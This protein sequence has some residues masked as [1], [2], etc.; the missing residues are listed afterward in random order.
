[1]VNSPVFLSANSTG[2]LFVSSDPNGSVGTDPD[3]GKIVRLRDVDGDGRADEALDFVPALNAPRGL[4]ADGNTVYVLHPPHIS[5]FIDKDGDGRADE[6][7]VLVKNI[8]WSYADRRADHGSNGLELGIDGWLYAAIGDFGFLRAEGVDGRTLQMRGGGIVRVRPDGTGM[9]LFSAGTRNVLEAAI[10]PLLDGFARDNTNDGGGWNTRFHHFSGLEDHGYPRLYKNFAAEAVAPLADYGGGSGC[11]AAWLSEPGWP[12]DWNHRPIT[13]DWG[14]ETVMAHTVQAAGAGF[15]ESAPPRALVSLKTPPKQTN[16]FRPTDVDVD[17]RG[18]LYLASWR[19]GGFGAGPNVG[20]LFRVHPQGRP[21][22]PLLQYESA[23]PGDLA[24]LMASPSHRTRLDAQRTLIR[25]PASA[26]AITALEEIASGSSY[27]LES[28]VAALFTLT[29]WQ[30]EKSLEFRKKLAADPSVAAWAIRSL[31]DS[32]SPKH[33]LP[34]E[35]VLA[36]LQSTDARTRRES[37]FAIARSGSLQEARALI[38]LLEDADPLVAHMTWRALSNL[39]AVQPCL[40]VVGDASASETRREGALRALQTLYTP[41]VVEGLIAQLGKETDF[42]RKKG[43]LSALSRLFYREGEWKGESWGTRPDHRGPLYQP[44]PWDESEKIGVT[45][46]TVMREFNGQDAAW[47]GGELARHRVRLN[48]ATR[49][50]LTLAAQDPSVVTTLLRQLSEAED[51]PQNALPLLIQMATDRNQEKDTRNDAVIALAKTDSREAFAAI[52]KSFALPG[53][54]E[55]YWNARNAFLDA[56]HLE[57]H[58]EL[59]VEQAGSNEGASLFAEEALMR[60]LSRGFGAPEARARA[61]EAIDQGWDKDAKRRRQI[62]AAARNTHTTV[63]AK[64]IALLTK[65]PEGP[66]TEL[67]NQYFKTVKLNPANLL[68]EA[69][70]EKLVGAM[71]PAEALEKVLPLKGDKNR[72]QQLFTQQGCVACHTVKP[73]QALKGPYLGNIAAT[74][75]KRELA[76]SILEP[77]KSIAQ[78]FATH[79]FTLKNGK[80]HTGFVVREAAFSVTFRTA[81]AQELTIPSAEIARREVLESV[82]LMPPGLAGS[83]SPEEFASLL[84]YL[85]SLS[86]TP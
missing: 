3:K 5:A 45:L 52:L 35:P 7:R 65:E 61:M 79:I 82:S 4:V 15:V 46:A 62:I 59:F 13:I 55:R 64:K 68:K 26:D 24:R 32:A 22:A 37:V 70:A 85:E 86:P 53:G 58:C 18:Y 47:L 66:L 44:E 12:A 72:G 36:G 74:Y 17:A 39:Q 8:G 40:E 75:K 30:P 25:R 50:L 6:E 57:N 63:L 76:E 73:E 69:P 16:P 14:R 67:V 48:D 27:A 49:H 81:A 21:S 29:L 2:D 1:M 9:E 23:L 31:T 84:T 10:S 33:P 83:L 60:L 42:S 38:P 28:R 20:S 43:I 34:L 11:G 19:N 71:M 41:A 56:P 51:I 54:G 78:G 77:S 80:Q